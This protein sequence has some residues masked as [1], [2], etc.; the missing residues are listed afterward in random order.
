MTAEAVVRKL[1]EMHA[2]GNAEGVLELLDPAVVWLGTR[3]GLDAG[4]I[5]RG[6]QEF[7]SYMTEVEQTWEQF[8][9]EIEQVVADGETVVAF[10]RE[11]A[12]GRG[13]LEVQN[14][15]AVVIKVH[16]GKIVEARGY[17]DRDDALAAGG[18]S[19]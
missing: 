6:P 12:R 15:T 1:F 4:R 9:V 5:S 13:G 10:L 7:L 11:T 18:L 17:L 2:Q 14:E 16:Q 3:G 8:D 19:E